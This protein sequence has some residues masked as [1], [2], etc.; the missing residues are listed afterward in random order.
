M[1]AIRRR[2]R[3]LGIAPTAILEGD[4][5]LVHGSWDA[6]DSLVENRNVLVVNSPDLVRRQTVP[7]GAKAGA[8]IAIL[9]AMVV[10]LAVDLVP[11]AVAA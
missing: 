6:V 9:A 7:L 1:L 4:S 11:P 10:L 3:E 5:I 8:A 2:G